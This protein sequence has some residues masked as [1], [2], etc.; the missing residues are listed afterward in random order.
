MRAPG[1][2]RLFLIYGGVTSF[3]FALAFTVA[4]VYRVESAGLSPL[5]L[6]LVG[7]T[8][9]AVFFLFNVPTGIVADTYSRRLSIIIGTFFLGAAFILEGA[10]PV[11]IWIVVAQASV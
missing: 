6:V 4:A 2:Y 3:L 8:L 5:Q 11:F 10:I 1:A 7:T 9:E